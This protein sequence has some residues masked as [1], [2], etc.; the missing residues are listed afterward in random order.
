MSV[1][2]P[3]SVLGEVIARRGPQAF[4][5]SAGATDAPHL[6]H[7]SVTVGDGHLRCATSGR[8]AANVEA[9]PQV[10]LLWPVT[11]HR[12]HSLLV[13]G[14]AAAHDSEIVVTPTRA[15]LH[16]PPWLPAG[17]PPALPSD[18]AVPG[19]DWG[20][21]D[22][23]Q[24]RDDGVD[25]AALA[26]LADMLMASDEEGPT[27]ATAALVV[28]HRGRIV[29]E[30]YGDGT[31]ADTPLLSWSMAKSVLHAALGLLVT[32]GLLDVEAP[33]RVAAWR[34]AGDPRSSITVRDL[35]EMRDGL[36]WAEDYVD[37]DSSD[38]VEMLFGSG[39][40]DMAAYASSRPA[41]HRP[42][43]V[44]NYSSGSSIVLAAVLADVVGGGPDGLRSFL[45]DRLFGPVGMGSATIDLD[46][47][48]NWV[49]SSAV[50]ATARDWAR[51]GLLYL[52]GGRWAGEQVLGAEWVDTARRPRAHDPVGD[53]G[54]AWH[55]WTVPDRHGTFAASGYEGQRLE[56]VPAL[57]LVVVRLGKTPADRRGALRATL[58]RVVEC[59]APG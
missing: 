46:P 28:V 34:R 32:D 14:E 30:R 48:G 57:D 10:V 17:P 1:P 19:G 22:D 50:K 29:C 42:G 4:L 44:F 40:A 21:A 52:R 59:F 58:A 16:R 45:A 36:A 51:F 9:S 31:D 13:D 25:P 56:V 47:A 6:K 3:I 12:G 20:V 27:G 23:R 37:G 8:A 54:Y 2:V 11:G 24:L 41:E 7:I 26:G 39:Y 38:V 49:A 18:G 5:V 33:A 35:L 53:E 15:M 43:E 55:W